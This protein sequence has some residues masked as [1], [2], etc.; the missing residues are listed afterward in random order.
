MPERTPILIVGAGP[1]GLALAGDLGWRGVACTLVE[2]TDGR[3]DHPKMDLIGVRTM[4]FCRRWGIADWVRDAPYP[5]DYPQDYVWLTALNGFELGREPFPGR[6]FEACPPQSPQKRERVPQDMFD[7]IIKKFATSFPCVTLRHDTELL[8]F[9]EHADR[10]VATLRDTRRGETREIEAD[11][12]IGTDGAASTVREKL[13]IGMSGHPAL[14]YTTNVIFR[15]ADF[16]SLHDKGKAYRFIFIGPEGTWLTIVAINGGDRFRMSI[17]GS[18]DKVDHSEADIRAALRRAM[19][20]DFDYEILSV[21]RWVRRELVAESY[22]RGRVFMAG[23]AIH[24]TSPTG[25]LGMN[26]GMQDAVDLGWKVAAVL[27]GWGGPDLLRSYEIERKPVAI[28]NIKASTDNLQRMIAP[29]TTHKPPP[30]VFE[31]GPAGDVA[32]KVYGEWYTELMRHEWFMNGYHL[33]Y[34]YDDSPIVWP[35][36]TPAPP[37]EGMTYTQIARPGARAPHVWLADGR[38]TLDLFG[39]GFVLLRIGADAPA[40]ESLTRAAADAGVP[41]E[42]VALDAPGVL[43]AYERRL[44]LV[45]PDGHVAWRA[46]AEP[47]DARAVMNLVRG[48][49]SNAGAGRLEVAS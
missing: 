14:T 33:G 16:A 12:L 42:V 9:E 3:I 40:S 21:M 49:G 48:A 23:D 24:L 44:V 32:R 5:G 27:Q 2:K 39:R 20:K 8:T 38:S 45:R 43:D 17:V 31:P 41:L 46:D 15:C 30:D 47:R 25:A 13:G 7:P 11:Y 22:G 34:R 10:V 28:R 35:D 4:E 1:V 26:T 19:G 29:R 6:A 36:G 18:P 37:L